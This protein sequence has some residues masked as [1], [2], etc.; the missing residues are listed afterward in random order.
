[1]RKKLTE[2]TLYPQD[3][4][5]QNEAVDTII[6][7]EINIAEYPISALT[8]KTDLLELTINPSTDRER[9]LVGNAKVGGI[10][11]ASDQ[12]YF[13]AL[14]EIL[15]EQTRFEGNTIYF[16]VG[17]LVLKA[18]KPKT[19]A[20]YT[21][22]RKA[23][24]K[25]RWLIIR[26]KQFKVA[27]PRTEQKPESI[28]YITDDISLI[29]HFTII[30]GAL[31]K[32]R[33]KNFTEAPEGYCMVTF[34]D[35]L[36]SNLRHQATSKKLNFTFM[37]RLSTALSK[38]YFRMIDLW[39]QKEAPAEVKT[40][41]ITKN[42]FDI[43]KLLPLAGY[44]Y[45]SQIK[46]LLDPVHEEL[47]TFGY[48]TGFSYSGRKGELIT[49]TFSAYNAEQ[50]YL[51][52]ELVKKGVSLSTAQNLVSSFPADFISDC[53]DYCAIKAEQQK[54][55]AGYI[56]KTIK[57]A[58][59]GSLFSTLADHKNRKRVE[60]ED[61]GLQEKRQLLSDYYADIDHL[62]QE[63]LGSLTPEEFKGIENM[64]KNKLIGY[65]GDKK[66][67]AYRATLEAT[68]IE[69]MKETMPRFEEWQRSK[70]VLITDQAS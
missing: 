1:L 25:Y 60:E 65:L 26:A 8:K 7:D 24:E 36:I 66:G 35:Y 33:K 23:V 68:M 61:K 34:S 9:T 52:D 53:L 31:V 43:Q 39:R 21:R 48:I 4:F 57:E 16:T 2:Q 58:T 59:H 29:Q 51:L 40:F 10:P 18:G 67:G 62:A 28:H 14:L 6:R 70:V 37:M 69:I 49:Y 45:T 54:I 19:S 20:E 64:A 12:D 11:C 63:K 38:R 42:I 17:E 15:H 13:Y 44:K 5:G 56:V 3:L 41:E 47:K 50:I 27:A 22:A 30:G 32:G 46:R 55:T